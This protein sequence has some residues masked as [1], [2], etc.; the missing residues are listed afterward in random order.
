MI[1][2]SIVPFY[3]SEEKGWEIVLAAD[4]A[5]DCVVER[6]TGADKAIRAG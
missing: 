4:L 3:H 5:R 1:D 6:T 2:G